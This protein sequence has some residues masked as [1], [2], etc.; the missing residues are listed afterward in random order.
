MAGDLP[1]IVLVHGA[2]HGGWCWQR[3]TPH[4]TRRGFT[5]RTVDLPSVGARPGEAVGLSADAAAVKAALADLRGP[6]V[7]CGHS[8]GGMVISRAAS[9]DS[10]IERLL[11]VCAYVPESGQSVTDIRGGKRLP[12]V[13]KLDGGLTMADPERAGDLLYGGCDSATQQW[14]MQQLRPQCNAAFEEAVPTPAWKEVPSTYVVCA[15]D[16]VIAPEL[17]REVL[18]P[19][20][21]RVIELDSGHSPFLSMPGALADVLVAKD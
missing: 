16:R 9:G 19:R 8:Y 17:Q 6:I 13:Q 11:Y 21:T 4:L 2:W 15:D 1:T 14:A 5:C 20:T 7:L 10:R 3:L 12:W 18:A